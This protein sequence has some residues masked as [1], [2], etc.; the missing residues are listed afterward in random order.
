M[1]AASNPN[2][3]YTIHEAVWTVPSRTRRGRT[4]TVTL[5]FTTETMQ[6]S[7]EAGQYNRH[8]WHRDLV[9]EGKAGKPRVR[10]VLQAPAS[11]SV[12][13][14]AAIVAA[15]AEQRAAYAAVLPRATA[16]DLWG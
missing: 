7:C 15:A 16:A 5:D 1:T 14:Q 11:A 13:D 9:S 10:L 4:H 12:V 2:A 6:C 3:A 8:C